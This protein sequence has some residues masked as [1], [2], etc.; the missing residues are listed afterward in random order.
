MPAE[1]RAMGEGGRAGP[2]LFGD[3]HCAMYIGLS[4]ELAGAPAGASPRGHGIAPVLA[5]AWIGE[6]ELYKKS[7]FITGSALWGKPSTFSERE[8]LASNCFLLPSIPG[9]FDTAIERAQFLHSLNQTPHANP[10]GN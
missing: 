1:M 7:Q 8:Q 3:P 4:H 10:T 2:L 6:M 5:M 9:N